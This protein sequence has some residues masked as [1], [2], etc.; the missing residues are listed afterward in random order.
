MFNAFE[1]TEVKKKEK[2]RAKHEDRQ[3]QNGPAQRVIL[4][5]LLMFF[6]TLL[7]LVDTW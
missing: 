5:V 2:R 1:I 4:T 3:I 6:R 7:R